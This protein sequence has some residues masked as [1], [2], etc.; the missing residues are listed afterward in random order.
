MENLYEILEVSKNASKEVIDK[1]YKVL[2]KKYHPDTQRQENRKYAEEKIKKLN[3]AYDIISNE[4]KRKEY[5]KELEELE[6]IEIENKVKNYIKQLNKD[7]EEQIRDGVIGVYDRVCQDFKNK[8]IK[9]EKKVDNIKKH[10]WSLREV[11]NILTI[12]IVI[13]AIFLVLWIIPTTRAW[14]INLYDTNL[15]IKIIVN[16]I[17]GIVEGTKKF[18]QQI[19]E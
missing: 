1:A 17:A 8:N 10:K 15:I 11:K 3:K 5:D 12:I 16:I 13:L 4:E 2:A 7:E 19:F 9:E 6:R 18:F 14:L